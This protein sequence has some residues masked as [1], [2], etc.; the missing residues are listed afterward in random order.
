MKRMAAGLFKAQCLAVMD[1]VRAK[2]EGVII[3]KR[4]RPVVKLV[5]PDEETDEIYHFLRG[6]GSVT[7]DV[8][9]P[10][11]DDWGSLK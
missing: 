10:A 8:V 11:I 3:T 4:G 6:K 9:S 5:P 1:Q 7:G 2:R